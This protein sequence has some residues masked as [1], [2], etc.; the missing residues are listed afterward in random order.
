MVSDASLDEL[1]DF[2]ERAGLPRRAFHGDH[3]DVPEERYPEVVEAA[4]AA[5]VSMY[6]TGTRHFTH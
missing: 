2:A 1:H 6:F 3:Y 4:R 5:G